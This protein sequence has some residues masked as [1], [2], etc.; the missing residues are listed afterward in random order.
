MIWVVETTR[1]MLNRKN[2][3]SAIKGHTLIDTSSRNQN[4]WGLLRIQRK[5][6]C[7]HGWASTTELKKLS[8]KK[9]K[10]FLIH[11]LVIKLLQNNAPIDQLEAK[12]VGHF[13]I[14]LFGQFP[15]TIRHGMTECIEYKNTAIFAIS[16]I[17][18]RKDKGIHS[19]IYIARTSVLF[20]CYF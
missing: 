16:E 6:D 14:I 18:K 20:F 11:R 10:V 1:I 7:W 2:I 12:F 17:N 13:P 8:N 19:F 9:Q 5:N 15:K 4:F 3:S